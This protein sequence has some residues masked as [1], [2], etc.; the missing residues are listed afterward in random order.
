MELTNE[1]KKTMLNN[2][3]KDLAIQKYNNEIKKILNPEDIKLHKECDERIEKM[4]KAQKELDNK[5]KELV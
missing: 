1:E 2:A 3:I 4:N 5:M